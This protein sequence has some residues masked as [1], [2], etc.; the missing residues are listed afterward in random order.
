[1]T[2]LNNEGAIYPFPFGWM[3]DNV[4][5]LSYL[6]CQNVARCPDV[7]GDGFWDKACEP[8]ASAGGGDCNDSSPAV[9]PAHP[10]VCKNGID[11]N[12]NGLIDEGC[13]GGR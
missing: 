12:C 2:A 4:R 1:V 9:N 7:D 11:D 6:A 13:K 5:V 10:E 3:V 8:A